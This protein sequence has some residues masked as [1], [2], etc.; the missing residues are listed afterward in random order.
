MGDD[1]GNYID[2]SELKPDKKNARA[3]NPRN[4]GMITDAIQEIGV[5]RSGVI[6]EDGNILAGNGTYEALSEAGIRKVKVVDVDGEEWV[7]VRR[8]GLTPAEKIKLS[9]YDNRTAEIAD[10]NP[11]ILKDIYNDDP[12]FLDSIFFADELDNLLSDINNHPAELEGEDDAPEIPDNPITQP[13][14]IY[15]LGEHRLLCGDA[16]SHEDVETL[17]DGH[18]ANIVFTDP[19]YNVDYGSSKNHPSWHI[20]SIKN[21]K[22]S[23]NDWEGFCKAFFKILKKHCLGDMYIWGASGPEGMKMR[24]WLTEMDCHWS[25]TIIWKKQQLVLSPA[26]YQ[27]IYEPCFY[28]W[29]DKSSFCADRKQ[30]EV[31]EIDRPHISKLHPTMKPIELCQTGIK[32]SSRINNIVLDLF[33]GSGSTM[34]ASEKLKRKCYMMELDAGYCDVIVERYKNLFPHKP[35]ERINHG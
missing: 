19:P 9:L 26:K 13:G 21:D 27:R 16:T 32:N 15:L 18:K 3:H 14:D 24:L 30:V 5:S 20:R 29:F 34:I 22:L 25:S 1:A 23:G 11:A 8:K 2:L 17:M 6:D 33:G 12:E 4:I 10:W 28:G 7:V 31:W 35:V